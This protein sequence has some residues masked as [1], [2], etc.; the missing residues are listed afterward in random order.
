MAIHDD[1][2]SS[3]TP[4][5]WFSRRHEI[6]P[7]PS[8]TDAE[9]V[10]VTLLRELGGMPEIDVLRGVIDIAARNRAKTF[11]GTLRRG[12]IN[13]ASRK[14][15]DAIS[16]LT[17]AMEVLD[18]RFEFSGEINALKEVLSAHGLDATSAKHLLNGNPAIPWSVQ[19][20]A[21]VEA[22]M[23]SIRSALI[24]PQGIRLEPSLLPNSRGCRE[25]LT[26]ELYMITY[27][28]IPSF[29]TI[30]CRLGYKSP[31]RGY[32][33]ANFALADAQAFF[34]GIHDLEMASDLY[35]SHWRLGQDTNGFHIDTLQ[36][37]HGEQASMVAGHISALQSLWHQCVV[38]G[39]PSFSSLNL[40]VPS[41]TDVLGL[42]LVRQGDARQSRKLFHTAFWTSQWDSYCRV[43]TP[44]SMP[45][46]GFVRGAAK[47]PR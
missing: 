18:R 47:R 5:Y 37:L 23:Q 15:L 29:A 35:F 20:V 41:S 40:R 12:G 10:D 26:K 19:E 8:L 45:G 4:A 30:A 24:G 17:H 11:V 28:G 44:P 32:D 16:R 27:H 42:G 14:L 13:A 43:I 25:K 39:D 33:S 6:P 2:C 31:A 38:G 22:L 3:A 7:A 34:G 9:T 21:R 36:C 1:D 46:Y